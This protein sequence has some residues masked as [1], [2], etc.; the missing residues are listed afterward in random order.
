MRFLLIIEII[1]LLGN[2]V[3]IS[4][5]YQD[6]W[7]LEGLEIPFMVFVTTY[8]I[9]FFLEKKIKFMLVLATLCSSV[10]ALI[11]NLKY[12]W[13][14]GRSIDQHV[15]Y[16][17]SGYVLNEGYIITIV[18]PWI[19]YKKAPLIHLFFSIFSIISNISIIDSFKFL[20]VLLSSMYPLLTFIIV[21]K[22]GV[23][24]EKT[25]LRY[26]LFISSIPIES[27]L[28][29]IV[30]GSMFGVLLTFFILIEIVQ[31]LQKH[32]KKDWLILIIFIFALIIGHSYSS[33]QIALLILG[34]IAMQKFS[35]LRIKSY[36]KPFTVF[37]ILLLNL[38]WLTLQTRETFTSMINTI[39]N[40]GI[41]KKEYPKTG[42][43]PARTFELAYLNI[44]ETLKTI[45][46]YDG[47]HL[48]LLF[49]MMISI[50]SVIKNRRWSNT[51][52]FLCSFNILLFLFLVFGILSLM[53]AYYWLRIVRFLSISY[54][55]FF[56]ILIARVH[57]Y[58]KRMCAVVV[59]LLLITIVSATIQLYR[60]QPLVTSAN[61]LS[62][63]LPIDEPIVYVTNVN[64]IYQREM[65]KF[66]EDY[67]RGRFVSDK[68]TRNQ[69]RGLSSYNFWEPLFVWFYPF[70]RLIDKNISEQEYDFF[71][72]HLPG[73]SGAF[74]EKAEI[75]TRS[76]ILTTINNSTIIYT[77]CESY[78]LMNESP[79]L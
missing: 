15:Q 25:V 78:I 50:I 14:L 31:L 62:K 1:I 28:S 73:K 59:S 19:Y 8:A 36:I 26:A 2:A 13:F 51:L 21:K 16:A 23:T 77:N 32:R 7:V 72:I 74:Q 52:K 41:L 38:E 34:I 57:L 75:R 55:I 10:F 9:T 65:I 68:V 49:L 43:I 54:G 44:F 24:K 17:L 42:V 60:C 67:V 46:V 69:I 30:T 33:L 66:A 22:L 61:V 76:L 29:Y 6:S 5:D 27:A 37:L 56:G 47:A 53:G 70:S 4:R 12:V 18:G 40:I 63:D 45:S 39:I 58:N 3:A 11:P 48:F 35:S 20:P 71:L 64:S 79:S